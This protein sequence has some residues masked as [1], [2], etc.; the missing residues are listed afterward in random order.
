MLW[1]HVC[2]SLILWVQVP[3]KHGFGE[4]AFIGILHV[5]PA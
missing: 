4:H 5:G 3:E 2:L 1:I